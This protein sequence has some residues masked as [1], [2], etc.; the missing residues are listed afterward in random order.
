MDACPTKALKPIDISGVATEHLSSVVKIGTAYIDTD[1]CIPYK[2]EQT[3]LA[4]IEVCPVDRT[5]TSKTD[6]E[7][8]KPVINEES[9]FGCGAC[10]KACPA[11]PNA[12]T[13]TSDGAK[14]VQ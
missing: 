1:E 8:R 12:I 7:P 3:C 10:E 14:R 2:L 6:E 13:T 4:C 11:L 9:C 5:I